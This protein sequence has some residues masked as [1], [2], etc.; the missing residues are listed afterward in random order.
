M[1]APP[2]LALPAA[3]T[4]VVLAISSLAPAAAT[5]GAAGAEPVTLSEDR[6]GG[7]VSKVVDSGGQIVT[8]TEDAATGETVLPDP[9]TAGTRPTGDGL[10]GGAVMGQWAKSPEHFERLAETSARTAAELDDEPGTG[11]WTTPG[12]DATGAAGTAAEEAGAGEDADPA[13]ADEPVA[14][15]SSLATAASVPAGIKG[16]DVSNWQPTVNWSS[17][18]N[19]GSR[20]AYVKTSEGDSITNRIF[21]EQYAGAGRVG[22]YRGGYHFAIPTRDSS[23]AK[24]ADYFVN[25]GGGWSADGRT[26]PGLL[27]IEDNPYPSLYGNQCYGF[28]PAEMVGW[29]RDFSDRYKARTGRLPA[30]YTNYYFWRDCTGNSTAFNDHPLHIASYGA[31]PQHPGGWTTWD[32]WQYTDAGFAERIDANVYRGTAAQL[33]DLARNRYH[34]PLGGRAPAGIPVPATGPFKDVPD[35]HVFIKQINWMHREGISTGWIRADGIRVYRPSWSVS[36]EQMAAFLYRM[37]GS[38]AHTP[39]RIS[40]FADVPTNHVFYK[41]IS[42]LRSAGISTGW[43]TSDGTRV[44]RPAQPVAR[45]QMAAFL[46]RLAGS[47]THTPPRTSPF[48]DVSPGQGFYREMS[49]LHATGISTGWDDGTFRPAHSV[50]REVMAA[51]LN[52]YATRS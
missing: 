38:P 44:Y 39:P 47:P 32:I 22:M 51:F 15:A 2:H 3:L 52:R 1:K 45:D 50:S 19:Q 16:T 20:F 25:N 29:I 13:A 42:W 41:E 18:W 30:I 11:K 31:A 21:G 24:Q 28:S 35:N 33:G 40:P 46:H 23:G 49:W 17:L 9:A 34:K 43:V 27:D 37:A 10:D 26:L 14:A 6:R 48:R 7:L 12:D 5:D 36:R 4:A 8:T